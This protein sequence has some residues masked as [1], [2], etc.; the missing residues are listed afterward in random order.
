M[1]PDIVHTFKNNLDVYSSGLTGFTPFNSNGWS[2]G[3]WRYRL[4]SF[5]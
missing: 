5:K 1:G 4:V 2:L 3:A